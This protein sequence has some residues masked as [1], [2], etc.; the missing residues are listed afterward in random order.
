MSNITITCLGHG[1]AFAPF[2]VGNTAFLVTYE[3]LRILVDCGYTV[4]ESLEEITGLTAADLTHCAITHL[5]QDHCGGLERILYHR[6][7]ISKSPPLQLI[8][9]ND[10]A[11]VWLDVNQRLRNG[12]TRYVD[13]VSTPG[14]IRADFGVRMFPTDHGGDDVRCMPVYSFVLEIGGRNIFFSGDRI[15]THPGYRKIHEALLAA[16]IAFHDLELT[17]FTSGAHT[18]IKD[19]RFFGFDGLSHVRWTHHSS[20]EATASDGHLDYP[21]A[22]RGMTWTLLPKTLLPK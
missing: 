22:K 14:H 16:D 1:G 17:K 12:L 8:M 13:I 10:V 4:P 19:L 18:N 20:D 9:G 2:R 5:H 15:W 7:Y 11:S 3:D 21:L 6:R